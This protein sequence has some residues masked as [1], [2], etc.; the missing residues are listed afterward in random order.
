MEELKMRNSNEFYEALRY[1]SRN[2]NQIQEIWEAWNGVEWETEFNEDDLKEGDCVV[3]YDF[4]IDFV[5]NSTGKSFAKQNGGWVLYENRTM[6]LTE[7]QEY[8]EDKME[9]LRYKGFGSD[10]C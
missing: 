10:D 9:E 6:L 7:V 1:L 8:I 4:E 3:Y 5:E 2:E